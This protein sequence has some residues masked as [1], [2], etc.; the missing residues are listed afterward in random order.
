MIEA[1]IRKFTNKKQQN[2]DEG[3]I[4]KLDEMREELNHLTL[5]LSRKEF[6]LKRRYELTDEENRILTKVINGYSIKDITNDL[7][8]FIEKFDNKI[9]GSI[10]CYQNNVLYNKYSPNLGKDYKKILEN[11]FPVSPDAGSCGAAAYY[12]DTFIVENIET[13]PNWTKFPK[14]QEAALDLGI[15]SCWSKPILNSNHELLGTVALYCYEKGSPNEENLEILDWCAKVAGIVIERE[16]KDKDLE[17]NTV[18]LKESK[19]DVDKKNKILEAIINASGGHLWYKDDQERLKFC[20][21]SLK[22]ILFGAR[23]KDSVVGYHCDYL[24]GKFIE[25]NDLTNEYRDIV[26]ITEKHCKEKGIQTKYICGGV[27]NRDLIV[28]EAIKTPLYNNKNELYGTVGAAWDRSNEIDLLMKDIQSL[29]EKERIEKLIDN[30]YPNTPFI[31]YI[32]PSERHE[33]TFLHRPL[34][35]LTS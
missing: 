18:R 26:N 27:I 6:L 21:Q 16:H 7:I 31:Y 22:K 1:I 19:E 12:R 14:V 5:E 33:K 2:Y 13:H 29:K 20:D 10:L 8:K 9:I 24:I 25:E 17:E 3:N 34:I 23:E 11:G 35:E 28:V 32:L 15:K 4:K 30:E